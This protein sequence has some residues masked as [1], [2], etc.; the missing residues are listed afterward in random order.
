MAGKSNR[1][2]TKLIR[3]WQRRHNLTVDGILGKMTRMSIDGTDSEVFNPAMP[4]DKYLGISPIVTDGFGRDK[5]GGKGHLGVDIMFR[6]SK[7]GDKHLPWYTKHFFCPDNASVLSC[8][9]GR[10]VEVGYSE[11]NGWFV[12]IEHG[13]WMSVY[14]HLRMTRKD[15]DD[16]FVSKGQPIGTIGHAPSSKHG[17]NHLHFEI[18]DMSLD[19]SRGSRSLRAVDPEFWI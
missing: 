8:E 6:R 15:L 13:R 4:V 14:R 1:Y 12:K 11:S 17:I 2:I 3:D 18:W 16:S 19:G 9:D 5:R 10:V 7:S